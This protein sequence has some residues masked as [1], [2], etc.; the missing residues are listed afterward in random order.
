MDKR[1]LLFIV[2]VVFVTGAVMMLS[3]RVEKGDMFPAFSSLRADPLGA[4]ALYES[5][6]RQ[7]GLTVRRNYT[8][9]A[10][11]SFSETT[12]FFTGLSPQNLQ[13]DTAFASSILTLASLGNRV[14]LALSGKSGFM[15]SIAD[16]GSGAEHKGR[17]FLGLRCI[18]RAKGD[19]SGITG[20]APL[21]SLA[22]RE[23]VRFTGDSSWTG[24]VRQNDHIMLGEKQVKKGSIVALSGSYHL[25]NQGL[26]ENNRSHGS[27]PL[28]PFL[29][30]S[31]RSVVFDEWHHGIAH[32]NGLMDLLRRFGMTGILAFASAWFFLFI[33]TAHGLS[34]GRRTIEIAAMESDGGEDC[35]K[36]LLLSHI[37]YDRLLETCTNEWRGAFPH[38]RLPDMEGLTDIEKYNS[39]CK[40]THLRNPYS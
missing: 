23:A 14:I 22:W 28:I 25:S 36:H 24:V 26:R 39:L 33:W 8:K 31:S 17:N 38:K 21:A 29:V 3:M 7:K 11:C 15:A 6:E 27:N 34:A 13:G 37:S 4:R 30:G 16:S 32:A 9:I 2:L 19:S 40:K 1:I 35:L 12:L 5:L 18:K 10:D 20:P